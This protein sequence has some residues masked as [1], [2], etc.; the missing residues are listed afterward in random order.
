MTMRKKEPTFEQ[1]F[2]ELESTISRLEGG[3]LTLDESLA[4]YERGMLLARQCGEML[5]RAEL[6]VQELAPSAGLGGPDELE[7]ETDLFAAE[8]GNESE[9]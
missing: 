3:N 1:L 4:L 7:T 6:K 8:D 9:D 2:E 5:D